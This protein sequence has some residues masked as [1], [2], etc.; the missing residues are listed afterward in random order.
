MTQ[1]IMGNKSLVFL[2]ESMSRHCF[3]YKAKN[4]SWYM[5]L[6]D[7]EYGEQYD[8]DL[9]GP[10]NSQQAADDYLDNFSNPG[11]IYYDKKGK[12][13]VPKKAPNG[14]AIIS[15]KKSKFGGYY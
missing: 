12:M 15:P 6:A 1:H 7:D 5:E 2:N 13:K 11:G 14:S 10:F 4:G 3:I 8:S 9:Y